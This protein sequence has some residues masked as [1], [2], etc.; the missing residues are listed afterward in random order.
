L[1]DSQFNA[2]DA[3]DDGDGPMVNLSNKTTVN[4]VDINI[5]VGP[6]IDDLRP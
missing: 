5:R 2:I 3:L 1:G 6:S 4:D